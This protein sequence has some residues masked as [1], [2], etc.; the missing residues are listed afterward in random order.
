[1]SDIKSLKRQSTYKFAHVGC[2]Q[3]GITPLFRRGLNASIL[4]CLMD[5]RFDNFK[6]S[7]L[8]AIQT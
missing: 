8:A 3:I 2:V 5:L 7:L 6:D 1:K 4:C